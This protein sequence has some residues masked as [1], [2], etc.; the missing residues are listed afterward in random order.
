MSITNG[1]IEMGLSL[2]CISNLGFESDFQFWTKDVIY[3]SLTVISGDSYESPWEGSKMLRI[4]TPQSSV[5]AL[6]PVG[7]TSVY[8]DAV[9]CKSEYKIAF[10]M[11]TYDYTQFDLFRYSIT[12]L[13]TGV[14]LSSFTREAWGP[15]GDTTLKTSGWRGI[16]INTSAHIGKRVRFRYSCGGTQDQ[17]YATWVYL[18]SADLQFPSSGP[19]DPY[20]PPPY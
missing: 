8:Q 2:P 3:D 19:Y 12:D 10:S 9:I 15:T 7:L 20:V 5:D 16:T 17:L 11:F 1:Y 18:D 6:Q 14:V 13:D 4:G